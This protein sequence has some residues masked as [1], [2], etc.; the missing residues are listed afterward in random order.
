M[1]LIM[2]LKFLKTIAKKIPWQ[3]WVLSGVILC[4]WFYGL[5]QFERGQLNVQTKWD[6]EKETTRI[7][8]AELEARQLTV[9]MIVD[10][11]VVE[12]IKTIKEKGDV[13]EKEIPVFIPSYNEL[14]PG[15]F[16]LLYDAAATSQIPDRSRI[17]FSTSVTVG[18]VAS[19]T[20]RN[21]TTCN[22]WREQVLGWQSWYEE[23]SKLWNSPQK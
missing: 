23:Q 14:L 19:T 22:I 6:E 15:G 5:W 4:F 21:Y 10:S 13:I 2:M 8:I 7:R 20:N 3:V 17:P 1:W 9:N 16:R 18:D 11:V 12:R